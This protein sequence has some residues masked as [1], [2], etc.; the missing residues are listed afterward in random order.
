MVLLVSCGQVA[1]IDHACTWR[2]PDFEP[3]TELTGVAMA[4]GL[5]L[6]KSK[7]DTCE[8]RMPTARLVGANTAAYY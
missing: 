3:K 2:L 8:H 7:F 1:A 5:E 6:N 4:S